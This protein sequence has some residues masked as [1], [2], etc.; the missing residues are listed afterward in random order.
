[1]LKSQYEQIN[2]KSISPREKIVEIKEIADD[3][4]KMIDADLR[5][6]RM[7]KY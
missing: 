2:R 6:M 7:D 1:M 3:E 5:F 4:E